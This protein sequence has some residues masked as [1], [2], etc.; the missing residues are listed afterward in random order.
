MSHPEM[1]SPVCQTTECVQ[2]RTAAN[3]SSLLLKSVSKMSRQVDLMLIHIYGED[4]SAD[5]VREGTK[6]EFC[7]RL[8]RDAKRCNM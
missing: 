4:V 3:T 7:N 1:F 6:M 8:R 5:F 2:G